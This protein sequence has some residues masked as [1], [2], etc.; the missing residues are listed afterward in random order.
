MHRRR[1]GAWV[2]L[3][4]VLGVVVVTAG[5]SAP[6]VFDDDANNSVDN[7]STQEPTEPPGSTT[8]PI[9]DTG[10]PLDENWV[11]NLTS[12]LL[13]SDA[14]APTIDTEELTTRFSP[15]DE[16]FFELLGLTNDSEGAGGTTAA[17][18]A[19][20]DD[21]VVLSKTLAAEDRPYSDDRLE[22]VLAHEFAHTIQFEEGW[23]RPA[24]EAG[25]TADP[26]STEY[27]LLT[28]ALIE[29]GA[30]FAAEEYARA[31]EMDVS[32]I[33]RFDR[34]YREAPPD[35]RFVY[36]PY[37]HGGRY[38]DTVLDAAD[39]LERVYRSDPP[40]T[41]AEVLFPASAVSEPGDVEF[42]AGTAREGWQRRATLDDQAGAM[43]IH[44]AISSY[45]N[46]ERADEA[47][48]GWVNDHLF[49]FD[50]GASAS[51]AWATHWE[52]AADA[53]EFAAAFEAT[54]AARTDEQ[55]DRVDVRFAGDRTVVVLA[56][57]REFRE[58][59]VLDGADETLDVV[60]PA[61]DQPARPRLTQRVA[62]PRL[63]G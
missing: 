55:A 54:L 7:A 19:R 21:T 12:A 47:A 14:P 2:T 31:T 40:T 28:R 4:I 22:L 63:A 3:V 23:F 13:G 53:E 26:S 62:A 46:A 8:G 56:G 24:L 30:V 5:C 38:F 32:Q 36:A 25:E 15:P 57:D 52:S 18:V 16:P 42:T 37:H 34:R 27:R 45:T 58:S 20:G 11:Y 29:G 44:V 10:L 50:D 51:Y 60:L 49:A 61:A 33:G 35:R 41:T 43:L 9:N 1:R 6:G 59:V 48:S 39:N 17:A